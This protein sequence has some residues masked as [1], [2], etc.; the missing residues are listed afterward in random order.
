MDINEMRCMTL[1]KVLIVYKKS[2]YE[3][4]ALE[5]KDPN[6]LRLLKKQ[7]LAT[8]RS[9]STHNRHVETLKSVREQLSRLGIS[10][11]ICLRTRLKPGQIIRGYDLVMT[12]GG[13][14]T[15]LETSHH[16]DDKK[17]VMMGVNSVPR[18]SVGY[19]CKVTSKNFSEKIEAFLENRAKICSLHRL[20]VSLGGKMRPPL[21]LNDILFS[22]THPAGTTRYRLKIDGQEEEQKSS[23][24]WISPAPGSTA[25]TKS[26][27]G[28]TLPIGSKHFQF[29]TREPYAPPGR[30][31]LLKK[32]ILEPDDE[33]RILSVMDEAAL[34]ID[35][36]HVMHPVPRGTIISIRRSDRPIR[37]IW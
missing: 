5:L 11:D 6:Y 8:V 29:V 27:G 33:L 20:K 4:K 17:T 37:A 32:G 22:N 12:I 31:V 28:R 18:E 16:I 36:P 7:S 13:D 25:A 26:A 9:K 14:G 24:L 23:G 10:Y 35:G 21:A 1:R 19:Y 34:W 15:F 3:T 30:H 2:S